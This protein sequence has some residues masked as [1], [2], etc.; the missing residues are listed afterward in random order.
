MGRDFFDY[1]YFVSVLSQK[2]EEGGGASRESAI[3][4][5]SDET[6]AGTGVAAPGSLSV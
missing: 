5:F 2:G 4:L 3:V 1:R 6:G